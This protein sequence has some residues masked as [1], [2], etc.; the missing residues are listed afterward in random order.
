MMNSDSPRQDLL[1]YDELLQQNQALLHEVEELRI[2]ENI[3][4]NLLAETSRKLQIYSASIKAA[5]SSLL[6]YDI[7]WDSTNQHEFLETIDSSVNQ[8]SEMI[9]LLTLAF[10]SQ[11]NNLVLSR[12]SNMLQEILSFSQTN[13]LKKIPDIRL[14]VS[15]PADGK[16]VLVDYEYLTKALLLLYEVLFAQAPAETIRI[17]ASETVGGWFL[18]FSGLDPQMI[19]GIDQIYHSKA[20]PASYEFLSAENILKLHVF[21][22]IL[23]LQQITVEILDEPGRLPIMRLRVPEIAPI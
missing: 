10:R 16:P 15:F 6:N 18:D 5:V 13:A 11:A 2:Q 20:Q 21:C 3:I 23:H 1:S 17:A 8:V 9:V 14:E 19:K 22:E 12:D 7:F 4:W